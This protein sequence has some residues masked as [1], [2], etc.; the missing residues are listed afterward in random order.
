M[1]YN[2][3]CFI[4]ACELYSNT[5]QTFNYITYKKFC[6]KKIN[7]KKCTVHENFGNKLWYNRL[8]T[9]L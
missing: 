6:E 4:Y 1:H 8:V 2:V 3:Y 5:L 7:E 9:N